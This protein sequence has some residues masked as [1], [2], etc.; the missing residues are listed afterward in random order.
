MGIDDV[1]D[2]YKAAVARY[3]NRASLIPERKA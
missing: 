1:T 3:N 2:I